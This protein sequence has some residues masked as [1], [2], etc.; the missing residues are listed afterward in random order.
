LL[1]QFIADHVESNAFFHEDKECQALI[2]EAVLLIFLDF[3]VVL[4]CVFMFWVPCY[5]VRYDIRIK[6]MFGSSLPQVVHVLFT[7]FVFVCA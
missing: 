1:K 5:D 4:L 6:T 2:M 3:C 7:L